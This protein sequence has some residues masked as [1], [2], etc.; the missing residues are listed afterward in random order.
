MLLDWPERE[1][2]PAGRLRVR[3]LSWCC[4][5]LALAPLKSMPALG[6]KLA[7]GVAVP[8]RMPPVQVNKPEGVM[9]AVPVSEPAV[10][11]TV[12]IAT[13]GAFMARVPPLIRVSPVT[14]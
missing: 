5:P 14:L 1:T 4:E 3:W 2:V 11:C 7:L 9:L 10:R 6:L 12:L 8:A 13:G